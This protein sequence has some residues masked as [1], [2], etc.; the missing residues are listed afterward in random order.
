MTDVL[1][2]F[3]AA[4]ISAETGISADDITFVRVAPSDLL[5]TVRLLVE[6]LGYGRFIDLTAVDDPRREDRFELQYLVYSMAEL[7]WLRVKCRTTGEAPSI[8]SMLPGANWYEREV[9]DLFGVHFAGHPNL[10]RIM[11]PDDWQGHPLR[12]DEPI[13]GEPVDFV[14]TRE[15]YG[16]P[17]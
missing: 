12:R 1:E 5:A 13:G 16:T 8:T 3:E 14:A 11:M 9:Y 10:T 15:I 6:D 2:R 7:R 17:S 4:S